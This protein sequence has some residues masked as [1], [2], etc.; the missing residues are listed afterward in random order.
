[1]YLTLGE[2]TDG[3]II[4]FTDNA[5]GYLTILQFCQL[6]TLEDFFFPSP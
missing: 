1:M 4:L 3:G 2:V 6:F 5:V